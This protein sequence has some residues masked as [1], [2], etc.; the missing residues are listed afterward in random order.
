MSYPSDDLSD[1][2]AMEV[3]RSL[4]AGLVLLGGVIG[5]PA[6]VILN[7]S[8][9]ETTT[10]ENRARASVEG[11]AENLTCIRTRLRISGCVALPAA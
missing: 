8:L 3:G 11:P 1:D 7:A 5:T 6:N 10:G 4:G 2:A 9:V